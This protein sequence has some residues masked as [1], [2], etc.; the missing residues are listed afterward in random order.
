VRLPRILV[1]DD[2]VLI[3]SGI[4]SLLQDRCEM[5][6]HVSDGRALVETALRLRPDLIILDISMPL[7]SGLDAARQIKAV[8]PECRLLF[9]SVHSSVAHLHEALQAGASGYVLKSSAAEELWTAVRRVLAGQLYVAS[10]FGPEVLD[11]LRTASGGMRRSS[12]KL[13]DRQ[14]QV[15]QLVAQGRANK[16]IAANLGVAVKTVQFHRAHLMTKL[17]VHNAAEIATF[18][19]RAGLL[20]G[21]S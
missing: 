10:G 4:R 6:G 16:E 14:R 9:L 11:N 3:V 18:A 1:A 2:H 17:G 20:S 15:L 5:L 7:L 19:V 13:T 12:P 8:W 21:G